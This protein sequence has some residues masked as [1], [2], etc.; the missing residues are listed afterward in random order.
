MVIAR[1]GCLGGRRLCAVLSA[2]L[3]ARCLR[4]G[5]RLRPGPEMHPRR[6]AA[7]EIQQQYK[8]QVKGLGGTSSHAQIL[9]RSPNAM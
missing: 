6:G 2:V 8:S 5:H 9:S 4:N 1:R 3:E 7:A